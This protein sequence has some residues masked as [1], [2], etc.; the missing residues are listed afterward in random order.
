MIKF[1]SVQRG[2]PSDPTAQKKYYATVISD[3]S[4][5]LKELAEMVALQTTV[6]PTDCY[7]VLMALEGNVIRELRKGKI[8]RLGE[9]GSYRLSVNAEG[10]ETPEDVDADAVKKTRIIFRP[11]EGMS[12]M[13][14]SLKFKKT[15]ERSA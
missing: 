7:A 2:N 10:R 13:L 8:V 14:K 11:G 15:Q 5:E 6:S 3:G 1:K 12:D 9:L 4:T